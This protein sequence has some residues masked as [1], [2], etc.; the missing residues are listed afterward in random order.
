MTN[1]AILVVVVFDD[2]SVRCF[3]L[4]RV[5]VIPVTKLQ[6]QLRILAPPGKNSYLNAL[7]RNLHQPKCLSY[8]LLSYQPFLDFKEFTENL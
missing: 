2:V 6:S 3:I 1:Q 4:K 7:Y 5:D 8:S